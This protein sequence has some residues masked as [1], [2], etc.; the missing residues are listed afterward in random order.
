MTFRI[1]KRL[2]IL[3]SELL[4]GGE[5]MLGHYVATVLRALARQ[6]SHTS[7]TVAVLALGLTCFL[8]I[9]VFLLYVD[10]FDR[11]FPAYDRIHVVYQSISRP[12]PGFSVSLG[13]GSVPLLAE[14]LEVEAPELEAVARFALSG[15]S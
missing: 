9:G 13:P 8:A 3:L 15:R 5:S 10:S 11:Q 2:D 1:W 4:S 7:L 12:A 14:Q 6:V